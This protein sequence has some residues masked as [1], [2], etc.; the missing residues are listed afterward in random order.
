MLTALLNSFPYPLETLPQLR[1]AMRSVRV[2]LG[3]PSFLLSWD[4]EAPH[5]L[6]TRQRMELVLLLAL[7]QLMHTGNGE[8]ESRVTACLRLYLEADRAPTLSIRLAEL[9]LKSRRCMGATDAETF[10]L[11]A[12][13]AHALQ[14][15]VSEELSSTALSYLYYAPFALDPFT[16]RRFA[17]AALATPRA[18]LP[19]WPLE[20]CE[21]LLKRP[22]NADLGVSLLEALLCALLK[23]RTLELVAKRLQ[24]PLPYPAPLLRE[25]LVMLSQHYHAAETDTVPAREVLRASL[26]LVAHPAPLRQT[27]EQRIF[28]L[29]YAELYRMVNERLHLPAELDA[30]YVRCVEAEQLAV[31]RRLVECELV[32]RLQ[33]WRV[34]G[35]HSHIRRALMRV[36]AGADTYYPRV[37]VLTT[38][39]AILHSRTRFYTDEAQHLARRVVTLPQYTGEGSPLADVKDELEDYLAGSDPRV[40]LNRERALLRERW[41]ELSEAE[42]ELMEGVDAWMTQR[43]DPEVE[44]LRSPHEEEPDQ[45][46][47]SV[48]WMGSGGGLEWMIERLLW[49]TYRTY[50][51]SPRVQRLPAQI[52]AIV[53]VPWRE[54]SHADA[55]IVSALARSF[56]YSDR[57]LALANG[58]VAGLVG[59][60]LGFTIDMGGMFLLSARACVRIGACFGIAP[61]SRE[62]F[63]FLLDALTWSVSTPTADGLVA[64][65]M[66]QRSRLLRTVTIS[67][68]VYATGTARKLHRLHRLGERGLAADISRTA[69]LLSVGIRRRG[70]GRLLPLVGAV[71]AGGADY[72]F[73]RELTDAT[74]H[75]AARHWVLQRHGLL[76]QTGP[77]DEPVEDA[78]DDEAE[79]PSPGAN[80]EDSP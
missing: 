27:L 58:A 73:M 26:Y 22:E 6:P 7:V 53:G 39:L 29:P 65:L 35:I 80:R 47:G 28:D 50:A 24:D 77:Q 15:V 78:D 34:G 48:E 13:F 18:H 69:R 2:M 42:R 20:L 23:C 11:S 45:L 1:E 49:R 75:L 72:L 3:Q 74:L 57:T 9:L 67:G 62:G 76:S 31:A 16:C 5:P 33:P 40:L 21:A 79:T 14:P 46:P 51:L 10:W 55:G 60:K 38:R 71:L 25:V 56:A 12:A 30:F 64:T 4:P 8:L 19:R 36:M 41:D 37:R 59:G 61:G 44:L 70:W 17:D 52:E 68:V 43:F 66:D 32:R 63:R 54:L